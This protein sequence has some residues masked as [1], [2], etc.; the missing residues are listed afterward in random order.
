MPVTHPLRTPRW[1]VIHLATLAVVAVCLALALWQFGRLAERKADNAR[2]LQQMAREPADVTDLV[3]ADSDPE[4]IEAATYRTVVV[5]GRF[6]L[7]EEVLLRSRSYRGRAGHHLLTPL[8]TAGGTALI[9][10]RGWVPLGIDRPRLDATAPPAG[11]VRVEGVLLRSEPKGFLG[12][13]DPP[14]GHVDSLSRVDLKRLGEQLDYPIY[15]VYARL[16]GQDPG[17]PGGIPEPVE[18]PQPDDGPHLSYAL[19]WLF[20]AS[21]A[22]TAYLALLHK[23]RKRAAADK[24]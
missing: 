23:E 4:E 16:L 9:V 18:V 24:L 21:A 15:P 12:I 19:Q 5:T 1:I 17:N 8:L 6:D 22:S 10:D 13:S 20:F 7:E 3:H 14:E 11:K 2:L